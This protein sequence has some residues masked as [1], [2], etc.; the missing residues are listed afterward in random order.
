MDDLDRMFRQLVS[1]IRAEFPTYLDH[2]FEVAELYQSIIPYRHHR[3]A[4]GFETNQDYEL[5]LTRLLAGARGYLIG[6][7]RMQERLRQELSG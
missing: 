7:P 6:D 3:R 1:V 4:L 5:T 2:P